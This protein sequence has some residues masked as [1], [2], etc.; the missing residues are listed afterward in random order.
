MGAAHGVFQA[1]AED[2]SKDIRFT[3]S[4]DNSTLYAIL[5][6]WEKDQKEIILTSLSLK[7]G[8]IVRTYNPFNLS[9]ER[10]ENICH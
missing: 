3:R 5:L 2:T 8:S 9:M 7:T 4:K 6:G 10:P 1:P